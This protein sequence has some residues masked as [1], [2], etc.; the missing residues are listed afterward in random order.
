M[1]NIAIIGCGR[2]QGG[3]EGVGIAYAHANAWKATGAEFLLFGVDVNPENL[4]KFGEMYGLGKDQ[5]FSSTEALY[6][7]ITPNIVNICTWPGLHAPMVIEAANAGVKAIRCEK[8]IALSMLEV[9]NMLNICKEKGV[10]VALG[11]QRRF[12]PYFLAARDLLRSDRLGGPYVVEA[13]IS[14]GWDIMS[15][16]TH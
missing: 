10:R 2:A 9:Q 13:R 16:T 8:P 14:D 4:A 6:K 15:W 7:A 12:N 5:L 3:K 11:H 1:L